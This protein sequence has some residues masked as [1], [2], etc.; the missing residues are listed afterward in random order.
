MEVLIGRVPV[1]HAGWI[2]R[3]FL[4]PLFAARRL[5]L[6]AAADTEAL[7]RL[8]LRH[9]DGIAPPGL[10]LAKLSQSLGQEPQ[11]PHHALGDALTT[12]TAFIALASHLDALAPQTV[13]TILSA[14]EQLR[15]PRRFG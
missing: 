6:P 1:F 9:R 10:P 12:A 13:A 15:G 2:E 8:W 4:S 5:R 7:G 3:A 14:E 11:P